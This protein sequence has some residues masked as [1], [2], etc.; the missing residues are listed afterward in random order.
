MSFRAASRIVL[1][2][3]G[4]NVSWQVGTFWQPTEPT[5]HTSNRKGSA[6]R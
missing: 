1:A 3:T 6:P 5:Q 4:L 2:A